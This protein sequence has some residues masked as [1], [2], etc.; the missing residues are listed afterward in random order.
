MKTKSATGLDAKVLG[1]LLLMQSLVSHLPDNENV[2]RFVCQGLV[3]VPGVVQ[4]TF[5]DACKEITDPSVVCFPLEVGN[6]KYGEL[7]LQLSDPPA[8]APY[9]DYLKNFCFMLAVILEE[10]QQR[11]LIEQHRAQLEQRIQ[12]RTQQL[13]DEIAERKRTEG[14]LRES[15]HF[16]E[17]ILDTTPDL[18]YIYDLDTLRVVYINCEVRSML[19]YSPEG[20]VEMRDSIFETLLHPDDLPAVTTHHLRMVHASDA[21]Y[22][23]DYRVSNA[24]G[25]WRWLHSRSRAFIRDENGLVRQ[26]I[27]VARD[28]TEL[29]QA[30]SI[31]REREERFRL[32]AENSSDMI[33][34]HAPDGTYLYVSP[35]CRSLTGYE[36]EA[37]IG[38]SAFDFIHSKDV[39]KV[40]R[41]LS[42]VTAAAITDVT[43][44]RLRRKD[45]SFVWLE[46]TSRSV[47]DAHGDEVV[48]IQV[49]SRNVT[50]R[51][52]AED[53]VRRL[54]DELEQRVAARTAQLQAVNKELEAFSYSVSHD[55]RAPLR[56]INGYTRILMEKYASGFDEDSQRM[57]GIVCSET[58]RMGQLIDD[59]LAFSRT[60]RSELSYAELD[61]QQMVQS[62]FDELMAPERHPRVT[63]C[64]GELHRARGDA[65]LIR[66]VW[67]NL[68]QNALKFSSKKEQP[69]VRVESKQD[70]H[71]MVYT[72]RDNG[73]GFD[74]Q[75]ADK[76]FGV[77]KRLH[78]EHEFE[79][80]GVGLAIVQRIIQRHGGRV[81]AEAQ[82]G[83]GASF[84]FTL[85]IH[86]WP[87]A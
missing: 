54:N 85:P 4:A 39:T 78:T 77:F 76:L 52:Q 68:L 81:W 55:L 16:T 79:G 86:Q 45:G 46:S 23:M 50:E 47:K 64:L 3:D 2:F 44:F 33:S 22:E 25:E 37:L 82:V 71:E 51:K 30:A 58:Q 36:P 5:L 19:G 17:S 21:V 32:L 38:R 83:Q 29:K 53:E 62:V 57:F 65:V 43:V 34:C 26:I 56:A 60:G 24:Q 63:F 48:E 6:S 59:L 7:L 80:T 9:E 13:C 66:Q 31:L 40:A 49:A 8:F 35:A 70:N 41:A 11:R 72:V 27:G 20:I 10:R 61:M 87:W 12:A 1:Q 15:R 18:V 74:M 28:V 67:V 75:Y 69:S 73:A 42:R 14:A 84:S